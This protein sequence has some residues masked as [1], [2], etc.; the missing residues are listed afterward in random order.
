M[1]SLRLGLDLADRDQATDEH[2][3][4]HVDHQI[5]AVNSDGDKAIYLSMGL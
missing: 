5:A 2:G 1:I 3:G 4:A